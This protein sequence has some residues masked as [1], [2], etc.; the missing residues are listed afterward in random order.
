MDLSE[1]VSRLLN[2]LSVTQRTSHGKLF[3]E[4]SIQNEVLFSGTKLKNQ[5][6][7]LFLK[8]SP[9]CWEKYLWF[10]SSYFQHVFWWQ[11][12]LEFVVGGWGL[13]Q[14]QMIG[15]R[16]VFLPFNSCFFKAV[17]KKDDF[18]VILAVNILQYFST[19]LYSWLRINFWMNS[20]V[21]SDWFL[22]LS[23]VDKTNNLA[24]NT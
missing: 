15:A 23:K 2:Y 21:S 18:P 3:F 10:L 6:D 9:R 17:D 16:L 11:E 7:A 14:D 5:V 4:F 19:Q 13:P 22:H 20:G 12:C 1:M 8:M 24:S